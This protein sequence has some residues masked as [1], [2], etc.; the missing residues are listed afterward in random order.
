MRTRF[1]KQDWLI[2]LSLPAVALAG[3][4][5][6]DEPPVVPKKTSTPCYFGTQCNPTGPQYYRTHR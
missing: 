4:L 3:Y 5:S 2:W 6:R 1:F